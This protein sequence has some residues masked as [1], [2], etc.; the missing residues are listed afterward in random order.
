M[1]GYTSDRIANDLGVPQG[2]VLG[3]ILFV[4][5]VNDMPKQLRSA[6]IN[7][8]ADDT[9]IYLHGNDIDVMRNEMNNELER[10][11][12]WLKLNKLKLNVGKTKVMVLGHTSMKS[13]LNAIMM[14][15]EV[16]RIEREFKYL[17]VMLD[18][19]LSFKPNID[20]VCKKV[21]KKV[22]VM[23]RL[24]RILTIG[25]R[26]SIYKSVIAPHF[27]YCASII[28]LYDASSFDRMQKLQNRAMRAILRCGKLTPI[29]RMSEALDLLSVKQRVNENTMKFIHKLKNGQLPRYLSKMVRYNCDIHTYPTRSKSDFRVTCKKSVKGCNSVFHKG[30]V[31]FNSLPSDIKND[32][33]E[34]TFKKN[35]RPF[36]REFVRVM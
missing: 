33:C 25:A 3:A 32:K 20:Y 18:E 36:V 12:Q 13:L 30:L 6:F 15:G 10:V 2:S 19:K 35:L 17:G 8:F 28:Y 11:N 22:G 1:N 9:L 31:Q 26:L 23:S 4:L 21:A 27:D 29:V 5:Y 16:L 24:A 14:D 7:L 34:R